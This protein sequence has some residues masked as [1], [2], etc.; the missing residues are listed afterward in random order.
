[1]FDNLPELIANAE[2]IVIAVLAI[3][4]GA[5]SIAA[6]FSPSLAAKLGKVGELIRKTAN[7]VG[8]NVGAAKNATDETPTA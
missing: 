3:I 8:M 7:V 1:M 5:A 6:V 4:G 2:T